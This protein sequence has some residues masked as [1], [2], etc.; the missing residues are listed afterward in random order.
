MMKRIVFVVS[1]LSIIIGTLSA[2]TI[3][4]HGTQTK[5]IAQNGYYR[6]SRTA[7]NSMEAFLTAGKFGSY[8]AT[9]EVVFTSDNQLVVMD[10]PEG[11]KISLTNESFKHLLEKNHRVALLDEFLARYKKSVNVSKETKSKA[12]AKGELDNLMKD[13]M[14]LILVIGEVDAKLMPSMLSVLGKSLKEVGDMPIVELSSYSLPVCIALMQK[15]PQMSIT[16]LKGDLSPR[17]L[18]KKAGKLGCAYDIKALSANR[19]WVAEAHE[20]NMLVMAVGVSDESETKEALKTGADRILTDNVAMVSAWA[21]NKPL[22]KLMS[23]NIR[24]SGMPDVDGDNAWPKRKEAVVK[25][26]GT[27][28]PDVFGVQEMLP[29]Q[30]KYLRQE[31]HGYS[32][33]GVGRDDGL[34]EGECMGIF[35]KNDRF[36]LLDSGTFWL[37][38]T[39][40]KAT[41]GWDAACK[42]TVT[43]VQLKDIRSGKAF[44][45]FNTHL[46]H[47]GMIARQE[48]VKLICSE[49]RKLVRDTNSVFILGGDM[50]SNMKDPIF[51]PLIGEREKA[52][53]PVVAIKSENASAKV[54]G[55]GVPNHAPNAKGKSLMKSC[56]ET[57]WET[58]NMATYNAYGKGRT[59]QIDHLFSSQKTENLVFQTVR[60]NYGVPFISD[61][62]PVTLIFSLK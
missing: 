52:P 13:P 31:L 58:D 5:I 49:I 17:E 3:G 47:V 40:E 29:D 53:Q 14:K 39:P 4:K 36:T 20:R 48:S 35:F 34:M 10:Q 23:F 27:E 18:Q 8:A 41:M 21:Q 54:S 43:Y 7:P 22:V 32:M 57:S 6:S 61:H 56:R 51:A 25:M 33:V 11:K 15:F 50:N 30:Q 19:N 1:V 38:Q 60:K 62:Y 59:A 2:Q 46:D 28:N 44:Y 37:S 16:Y 24:M 26:I 45:Y 42:R 9:C 55:A 12:L